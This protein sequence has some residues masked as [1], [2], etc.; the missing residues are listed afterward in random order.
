MYS[1]VTG[2]MVSSTT[3]FSTSAEANDEKEMKTKRTA[4][5]DGFMVVAAAA[6]S[7]RTELRGASNSIF[8]Q[9]DFVGRNNYVEKDAAAAERPWLPPA[10]AHGDRLTL[11]LRLVAASIPATRCCR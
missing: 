11:F 7:A 6:L 9:I 10:F 4:N 3:I 8:A 2:W 5:R 1:A